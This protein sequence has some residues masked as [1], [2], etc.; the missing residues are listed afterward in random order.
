MILDVVL[1]QLNRA[2]AGLDEVDHVGGPEAQRLEVFDQLRY[3]YDVHAVNELARV[4]VR[5]VRLGALAQ[6]ESLGRRGRRHQ[7]QQ[8]RVVHAVLHDD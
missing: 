3:D 6:L 7:G 5:L 2:L 8:L 4:D 1:E